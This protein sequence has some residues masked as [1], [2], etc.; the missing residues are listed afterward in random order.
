M[1]KFNLNEI[2]HGFKCIESEDIKDIKSNGYIFR[3]EKSGA[4]PQPEQPK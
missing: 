2:Y 4:R 3:H 1:I